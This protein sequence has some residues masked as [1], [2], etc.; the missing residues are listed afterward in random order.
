M[1]AINDEFLALARLQARDIGKAVLISGVLRVDPDSDAFILAPIKMT[2]EGRLWAVAYG[3]SGQPPLV[4]SAPDARNRDDETALVIEPLGKALD[5]YFKECLAQERAPQVWVSSRAAVS[6]LEGISERRG[7][8]DPAVALLG[9]RLHFL[10]DRYFYAGQQVLQPATEVLSRHF[11]TGQSTMEDQHLGAFLEWI[12]PSGDSA[13]ASARFAEESAA[14][15]VTEVEM[16][17]EVSELLA[18]LAELRREEKHP[19]RRKE[20]AAA[21]H[22]TLEPVVQGI[23]ALIERAIAVVGR[24]G[25]PS[26]LAM[27]ILRNADFESFAFYMSRDFVPLRSSAG[28]AARLLDDR[29]SAIDRAKHVFLGHDLTEMALALEAGELVQGTFTE[30]VYGQRRGSVHEAVF[31]TEQAVSKL[32]VGDTVRVDAPRKIILQLIGQGAPDDDGARR[33]RFRVESGKTFLDPYHL[34]DV[35]LMPSAGGSFPF[36]AAPAHKP[37]ILDREATVPSGAGR[38]TP[39]DPE[40]AL[41]ALA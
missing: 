28:E 2:G 25:L 39:S 5:D 35:T 15:V 21:L 8:K 29:E 12:E 38:P 18:E 20:I 14:G 32:R 6:F 19:G 27:G 23:H 9:L 26:V 22:V 7:S 36:Y 1:S 17:F 30:F 40:A 24:Q 16:D 4:V 41:G 11:A 33:L 13:E 31:E 34:E 3:R 10:T 37:W